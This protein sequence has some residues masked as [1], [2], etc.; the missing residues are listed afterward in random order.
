MITVTES[1]VKQIEVAS[2]QAGCQG[3]PLRIAVEKLAD[4]QFHYRMGFDDQEET[5]DITL[6]F[7]NASIV[8]D[9]ASQAL[10]K[11]MTLDFVDMD[12]TMEFIFL[13]PN[14]PSF[15]EPGE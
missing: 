7:G 10:A 5:G 15:V 2:E 8:V 6:E 14:D 12:G 11:G 3:M 13:N 1:S 9:P 4:G